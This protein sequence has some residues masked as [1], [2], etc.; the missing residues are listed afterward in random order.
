[1][2]RGNLTRVL[3]HIPAD[4]QVFGDNQRAMYQEKSKWLPRLVTRDVFIFDLGDPQDPVIMKE[5][6]SWLTARFPLHRRGTVW[7]LFDFWRVY[8]K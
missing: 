4:K 3:W 5:M 6:L 1:M 8:P 2:T 7:G